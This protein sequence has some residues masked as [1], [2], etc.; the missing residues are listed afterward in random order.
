MS[1]EIQWRSL[2]AAE[3]ARL[4]ELQNSCEDWSNIGI[5]GIFQPESVRNC[6]LEGRQEWV[7]LQLE[8]REIQGRVFQSGLQDSTL[9]DCRIQ[10]NAS[11]ISLGYLRG[12]NLEEGVF[13]GNIQEMIHQGNS[14]FGQGYAKDSAVGSIE[15]GNEAGNRWFLPFQDMLP[16]DIRLWI[17]LRGNPDLQKNFLRWTND[18]SIS[19][20][21]L[22]AKI[23]RDTVIKNCTT[24]HNIQVTGPAIIS[25]ALKLE[26]LSIRGTDESPVIIEEGSNLKWGIIR[27]GAFISASMAENFY[28]GAHTKLTKGA[29]FI[30]SCLCEN[31]TI[32]CCEVI[33]IFAGAFHEQ[34]HNNSFL[35]ASILEGQSNVAA[36]ATIGSNHNSRSPDGEIRAGRGF[37][38]ALN[39]SLKHNSRFA[40]FTLIARGQYPYELNIALPFSLVSQTET[41]LHIMPAYWQQ[42]NLYGL[43]RNSWKFQKRDKRKKQNY[44]IETHWLAPDTVSEI[45][46]GIEFLT[47]LLGVAQYKNRGEELPEILLG[48]EFMEN[49][50]R[51]VRI[52]KP[53]EAIRVYEQLLDYYLLISLL[54]Y[55]DTKKIDIK[56]AKDLDFLLELMKDVPENPEEWINLA[57][58][59]ISKGELNR[60]QEQLRNGEINSWHE[61][62]LLYKDWMKRYPE[63]RLLHALSC[64]KGM[65]GLESICSAVESAIDWENRQW[66]GIQDSR[67]K[68][69]VHPFRHITYDSEEEKQALLVTLDSDAFI[70]DFKEEK[71]NRLSRLEK[72][73]KICSF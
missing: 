54:D 38:P 56:S 68:D 2:T 28:L 7:N 59:P 46:E 71:N 8:E 73:R 31:S 50:N 16:T 22:L 67:S 1:Q 33:S 57:G 10:G 63:E 45:R 15:A 60:W 30:H 43:C 52:I 23:S 5:S 37:W 6:R 70:Q 53:N 42:Y 66:K 20:K 49:S 9:R 48:N 41:E 35:I 21:D 40:S 27:E 62:H 47:N 44:L 39:L 11:V 4:Q 55:T 17:G 25:G 36:G 69:V 3:I 72:I 32:S 13:L 65:G 19:D 34:H 29:R 12:Y 26:E 58:T 64:R 18:I 14:T 61:W 24:I 51:P